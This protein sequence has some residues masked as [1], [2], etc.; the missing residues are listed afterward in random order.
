MISDSLE[1]AAFFS[2]KAGPSSNYKGKRVVTG[3]HSN[4]SKGIV[5]SGNSSSGGSSS[6]S[7]NYPGKAVST[8]NYKAQKKGLVVCE[9]CGYNGHTKES[10]YKLIGY[11][12]N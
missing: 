1:A 12:P 11:P 9:Y 5:F 6:S 3:T 4:Y 7:G 8:N 2:Q 10:Y